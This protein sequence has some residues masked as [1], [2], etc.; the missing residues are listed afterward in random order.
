MCFSHDKDERNITW[1]Q[2]VM[3]YPKLNKKNEG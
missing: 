3:E 2:E 1:N